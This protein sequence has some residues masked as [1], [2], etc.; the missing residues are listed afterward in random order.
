MPAQSRSTRTKQKAQDCR[1]ATVKALA[2]NDIER[3]DFSVT[4]I[5]ARVSQ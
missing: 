1:K 2:R 3:A 5:N 4:G